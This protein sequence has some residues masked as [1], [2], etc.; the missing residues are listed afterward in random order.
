LRLAD[1]FP[2]LVAFSQA[3]DVEKLDSHLHAHV[4][5]VVLLIQHSLKWKAEHGGQ[6]P[7]TREDKNLFKLQV[8]EAQLNPGETNYGEAIAQAYKLSNAYSL[9][10]A[11]REILQDEAAQKVG[12]NAS[13][14]WIKVAAL[15]Q[16]VE[17]NNGQLPL[18]GSIPD[19]TADTHSFLALQEVYQ[20]KAREDVEA[21]AGKVASILKALG[22]EASSISPEEI[23]L[24]CKSAAGLRL[25]RTRSLQQEYS[26]G[27]VTEQLGSL[28]EEPNNNAV[29]Y[30]L[31]RSVD[32][33]Y[34]QYG[35]YPG[36]TDEQVQ[37]DI[38]L[39]KQH[40]ASLLSDLSINSSAVPDE[41]IHEICRY[42]AAEL[43]NVAAF[44]GGVVSQEA[45]KVLTH[46]WV[47]LNN[48][49]IY[50]GMNSTTS[51]LSL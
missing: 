24:F 28:L 19:M 23:R 4:P 35:R 25:V 51:V 12:S 8:R 3:I 17:E 16:F 14:F 20:T 1:P 40:V 44:L 42:G 7:A 6:L 46:Q 10:G 48:T 2:G 50:N 18:N 9:P 39:L 49:L 38:P 27:D 41:A 43:H 29:F 37:T 47:P 45:I 34:A 31:L 13:S 26:K 15:R 21:V 33:F 32:R 36:W 30:L 5:F 22:R 11:V